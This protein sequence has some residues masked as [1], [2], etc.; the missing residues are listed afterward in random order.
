MSFTYS[1]GNSDEDNCGSH[2]DND[3]FLRDCCSTNMM[4]VIIFSFKI[5]NPMAHQFLFVL[6]DLIFLAM[7][8]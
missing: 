3:F 2:H 1:L 4:F 5:L 8:W 7:I 6:F